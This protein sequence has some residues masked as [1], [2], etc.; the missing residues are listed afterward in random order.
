MLFAATST[1][2]IITFKYFHTYASTILWY[3]SSERWESAESICL[4]MG[5]IKVTCRDHCEITPVYAV[6]SEEARG[7]KTSHQ[8]ITDSQTGGHLCAPQSMLKHHSNDDVQSYLYWTENI[9]VLSH[10]IEDIYCVFKNYFLRYSCMETPKSI[11]EP[12]IS[13]YCANIVILRV[14]HVSRFFVF[15]YLW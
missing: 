3:Q 14:L 9:W 11:W 1:R 7:E 10:I 13:L 15:I 5:A 4:L 6:S 2:Q 8:M 12:I